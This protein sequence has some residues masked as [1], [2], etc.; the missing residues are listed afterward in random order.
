MLDISATCP[1]CRNANLY[2]AELVGRYTLCT[3]CRTRFYVE[4]PPLP[5][6]EKGHV[7]LSREPI[8]AAKSAS[9]MTL[10]DLLCDTQQ[11]NRFV[12]QALWRLDARLRW[13]GYGIVAILGLLIAILTLLFG[14]LA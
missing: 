10:D 1:L 14:A 5:G 11:G 12:I 3:T 8:A 9:A 7:A 4:V 2:G 6:E 13:L